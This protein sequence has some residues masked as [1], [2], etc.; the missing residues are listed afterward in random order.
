M[1]ETKTPYSVQLFAYGLLPV[2][3]VSI[4]L[5]LFNLVDWSWWWVLAPFW[6]PVALIVL[7][8]IVL[9]VTGRIK[10]INKSE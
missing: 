3:L 8:I 2:G 5:K 7:F 1:E 10:I 4:T 6:V 9:V